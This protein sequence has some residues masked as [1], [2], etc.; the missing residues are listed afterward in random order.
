ML[1]F[2]SISLK[3][4][5]VTILILVSNKQASAQPMWLDRS[6]NQTIAYEFLKPDFDTSDDITF[7]TSAMFLSGRFALS[8]KIYFVG[9]ISFANYGVDRQFGDSYNESAFG[10]PYLGLEYYNEAGNIFGE[11][12]FRLPLAKDE[13]ARAL[14]IG[15]YTE[16]IERTEAFIS[17]A[18]PVNAFINYQS[19]NE[20]NFGIRFKAGLTGWFPTGIHDEGEWFL[21]YGVQGGYQTEQVNLLLG[22]SG[23]YWFTAENLEFSEKTYH[24]FIVAAD[25]GLG[26]IRPGLILKI[27][28]DDNLQN[29]IN[30]VFGVSLALNL[31]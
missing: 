3:L 28:L 20:S 25:F 22:L 5:F 24:Q 8:S 17:E 14:V 7:L 6:H 23:R 9:E 15:M 1:K 19:V 31:K 16:F 4:A 30:S 21:V 2:A 12:G 10:N 27:P 11:F 13:D 26:Q 18:I 29:M